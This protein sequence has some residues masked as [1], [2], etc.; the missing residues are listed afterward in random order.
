MT[1]QLQRAAVKGRGWAQFNV[2]AGQVLHLGGATPTAPADLLSAD[3][4][5]VAAGIKQE[6]N[7]AEFVNA[8]K[9]A[10]IVLVSGTWRTADD[11]STPTAARGNSS[12]D[13]VIFRNSAQALFSFKAIALTN[14]VVEVQVWS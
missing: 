7:G 10:D 1:M 12:L 14:M 6:T 5:I 2:N 8:I 4:S 11:G 13:P 9:H 3:G